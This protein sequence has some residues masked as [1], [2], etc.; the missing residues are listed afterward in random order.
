[1]LD[2]ESFWKKKPKST[3]NIKYGFEFPHNGVVSKDLDV[4][5]GDRLWQGTTKKEADALMDLDCFN[6]IPKVIIR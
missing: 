3:K 1:M 6:L 5:N 4:A 2:S